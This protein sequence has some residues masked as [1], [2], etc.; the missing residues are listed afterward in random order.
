MDNDAADKEIRDRLGTH[1][2]SVL[3]LIWTRYAAD[4]LGYLA[5]LHGSRSDAEDSLQ[6][7]FVTIAKKRTRVAG[8]RQ[9]KPYLFRL[10]RNVALNRIKSQRRKRERLEE[11]SDWLV[12]AEQAAGT[13]DRSQQLAAGLAALPEKQRA[14]LVLKFYREKTLREIGEMLGM[15]GNTAASCLRYGINKLRVLVQ[16]SPT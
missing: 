12:P 14:V 4:L 8:A 11:V 15:S 1:D 3:D 16:E 5:V 10:A 9:I 2:P 6:E 7:V 13:P